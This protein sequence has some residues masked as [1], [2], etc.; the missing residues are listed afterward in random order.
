MNKQAGQYLWDS[1]KG[2]LA[3][4]GLIAGVTMGAAIGVNMVTPVTT[5]NVGFIHMGAGAIAAAVGYAVQKS[6]PNASA[7]LGIG[8]VSNFIGGALYAMIMS[9]YDAR[10][11]FYN[12]E[13]QAPTGAL[14]PPKAPDP[15]Y[16]ILQLATHRR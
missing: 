8:G 13:T 10:P 15:V 11:I 1:T 3:G 9:G 5:R 4:S 7:G 16:S 12:K 6:A 2:A 14:M